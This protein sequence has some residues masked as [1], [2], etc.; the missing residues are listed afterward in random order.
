MKNIYEIISEFKTKN[1]IEKI[2]AYCGG[3]NNNESDITKIITDSINEFTNYNVAILNGGTNWEIPDLSSKIAHEYKLKVIGVLPEKGIEK[4]SSNVDL[5][6]IINSLYG[7]SDYGDETQVL[8]KLADGAI[9]M[10]G[11]CGTSIEFFQMMKINNRK[12]SKNIEP[13]YIVPISNTG[14][15]TDMIKDFNFLEKDRKILMP[16][17]SVYDGKTAANYIVNKLNLRNK[18]ETKI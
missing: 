18:D 12:I 7:V 13:T 1:N 3:F 4:K 6:I 9:F 11:S 5:D 10:G 14:G 17:M 8:A 15:I 2:I 16:Q